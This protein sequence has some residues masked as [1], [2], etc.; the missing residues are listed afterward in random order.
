MAEGAGGEGEGGSSRATLA[1]LSV[2]ANRS[3]ISCT[4]CSPTASLPSSSCVRC[5]SRFCP[6]SHDR[7]FSPSPRGPVPAPHII[8]QSEVTCWVL[9]RCPRWSVTRRYTMLR[10]TS[11]GCRRP[12]GSAP[13]SGLAPR[14]SS[15]SAC[16]DGR[17]CVDRS[18]LGSVVTRH[19]VVD[20]VTKIAELGVVSSRR[21]QDR[22]RSS[23]SKLSSRGS[24]LSTRSSPSRA[25]AGSDAL[26][27]FIFGE[28]G[29]LRPRDSTSPRATEEKKEDSPHA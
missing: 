9:R 11:T 16:I 12:L 10:F 26:L 20:F 8:I 21:R 25:S 4:S 22:S 23:T 24:C 1:C 17:I 29:F 18:G 27:H 5:F 7:P 3:A 28:E 6:R 2:F 13:A 15:I 19:E 14:S